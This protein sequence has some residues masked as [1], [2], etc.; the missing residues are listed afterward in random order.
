MLDQNDPE[1]SR[2]CVALISTDT[3]HIGFRLV[4]CRDLGQ[5]LGLRRAI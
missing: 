5:N 4:A 1:V 3:E 2:P